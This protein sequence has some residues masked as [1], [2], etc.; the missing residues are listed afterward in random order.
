MKYIIRFY[1]CPRGRLNTA[2][3]EWYTKVVEA[4]D[5]E[6][7]ALKAY[8]THD[9]LIPSL[10]TVTKAVSADELTNTELSAAE[11]AGKLLVTEGSF[12]YVPLA[13]LDRWRSKVERESHGG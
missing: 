1:A 11:D 7:A 12:G 2:M 9:H 8:D 10:T 6:A 4:D 5:V 3:K 13:W